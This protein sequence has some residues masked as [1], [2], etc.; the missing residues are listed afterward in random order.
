M[1]V[2]RFEDRAHNGMPIKMH[3]VCIFYNMYIE[4]FFMG[5]RSLLFHLNQ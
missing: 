3:I 1:A 4:Y 2:S 5:V